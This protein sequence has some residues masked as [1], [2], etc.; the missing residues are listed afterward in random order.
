MKINFLI[1]I[2][3]VT[4]LS[5]CKKDTSSPNVR[6]TQYTIIPQNSSGIAG[7]VTLTEVA[8]SAKTQVDIEVSH[9][10]GYNYVAHIHRGI[11]AHYF[12]AIYIFDPI[13]ASGGHLS[14]RQNIPLRYDSAVVYNGT[15]VIHDS[16]ANNVLGL[17]GVGANK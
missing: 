4:I 10:T 3:L 13:Y 2:I 8:D 16:T 12:N 14:Y 17:C 9:T 11:P 5:G 6:H 1:A 15:F 7:T